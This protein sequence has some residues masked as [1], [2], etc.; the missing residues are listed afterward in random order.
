MWK[1]EQTGQLLQFKDGT[2]IG[3]T[4]LPLCHISAQMADILIPLK[5]GISVYFA[6]PDALKVWV[7]VIILNIYFVTIIKFIETVAF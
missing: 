6:Q 5:F 3:V 7:F 1:A 2:E 4:F